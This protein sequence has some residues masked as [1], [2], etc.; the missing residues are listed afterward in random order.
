VVYYELL[1]EN[2]TIDV[3]K[4]SQATRS[5]EG[6]RSAETARIGQQKGRDL[7]HDNI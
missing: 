7:H 4:Y 5:F 3:T 6:S 1:P 2:Q